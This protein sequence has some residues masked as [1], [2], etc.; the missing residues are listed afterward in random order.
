M[1]P[2]LYIFFVQN[3]LELRS[4]LRGKIALTHHHLASTGIPDAFQRSSNISGITKWD[5]TLHVNFFNETKNIKTTTRWCRYMR[6]IVSFY[7]RKIQ[8][9]VQLMIYLF[10][11]KNIFFRKFI[12]ILPINKSVDLVFSEQFFYQG[13]PAESLSKKAVMKQF[14]GIVI[15]LPVSLF[16]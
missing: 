13:Y 10:V 16:P 15:Q 7:S 3:H 6:E 4:T 11:I 8:I 12:N 9:S 5:C 14:Y 2:S 1:I